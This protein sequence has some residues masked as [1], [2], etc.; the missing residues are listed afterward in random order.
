MA[1]FCARNRF[2][3]AAILLLIPTIRASAQ[4]TR[5]DYERSRALTELA[6]Q[7]VSGAKV[8]ARWFAEGK[9]FWYRNDLGG[10]GGAGA[11]EFILVDAIAGTRKAAFDHARLAGELSKAGSRE[12]AA[13]KLPIDEI[14]FSDDGQTLTFSALGKWWRCDLNQY[15]L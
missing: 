1:I 2:S 11:G 13:D 9:R 8:E 3:L 15:A 4:G 5:A 14:Q 6:R 7:K 12:I 10:R